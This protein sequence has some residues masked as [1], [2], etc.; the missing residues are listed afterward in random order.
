MIRNYKKSDVSMALLYLV[1][2][3]WK[4]AFSIIASSFRQE[5]NILLKFH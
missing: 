3:V 2:Y 5:N 4:D 1:T